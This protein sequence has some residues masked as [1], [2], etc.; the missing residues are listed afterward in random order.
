VFGDRITE[1]SVVSIPMRMTFRGLKHREALLFRG[2]QRWAEFSPFLEYEDSEASTWLASALSFANDPLPHLYR[3]QVTTNATLP[4]L[5]GEAIEEA[6][7]E[8]G[9][10]QTV[11]IKVAE[12][13]HSLEQ[14]LA[15]ISWVARRYPDAKIRLDANGGYDHDQ[16]MELAQAIG[17]YNIEYLEQPVRATQDLASFKGALAA[18]SIPIKIA[19]DE[20]IRK[21]SDPLAVA[22]MQAADIAVLKVQPLGGINEALAVA[23]ESGLEAVVSSALET[24]VGIA[25][26]LYLAGALPTLNYDCGLGTVNLLA[27]DVCKE[28]LIPVNSML[29]VREVEPDQEM[30]QQY[31]A[32]P[33]RTAWWLARLSRCL[34]LLES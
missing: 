29:E 6:L 5:D 27:G 22:R 28:P 15:R 14:D 34:E 26:S 32:S 8:F 1:I 7:R 21:S 30:L 13:G 18:S 19:A 25:Q 20:S 33:E 2:S 11:K 17:N 16:A 31:A 24:S 4:A 9:E 23:S 10:F 12:P 3:S